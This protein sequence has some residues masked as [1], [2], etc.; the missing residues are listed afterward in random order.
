MLHLLTSLWALP[1]WMGVLFDQPQL[2][3]PSTHTG[4]AAV[5]IREKQLCHAC[6][7]YEDFAGKLIG[8]LQDA[9]EADLSDMEERQV[10]SCPL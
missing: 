4:L 2:H 3:R 6:A 5:H 10:S 9:I 8:A 7:G 1:F